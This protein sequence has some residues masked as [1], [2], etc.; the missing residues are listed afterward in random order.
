MTGT[1]TI[2]KYDIYHIAVES[3]SYP[4]QKRKAE[5]FAEVIGNEHVMI[6]SVA[7]IHKKIVNIVKD[8]AN[9]NKQMIIVEDSSCGNSTTGE[10]SW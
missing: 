4:N 1:K 9:K 2:K 6:S 10:I 5:S 7:D 8:F 3:D